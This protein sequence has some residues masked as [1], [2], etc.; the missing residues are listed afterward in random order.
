MAGSYAPITSLYHNPLL[1]FILIFCNIYANLMNNL[2]IDQYC[3]GQ[4]DSR[5]FFWEK[6]KTH[7][8]LKKLEEFF[9]QLVPKTKTK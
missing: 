4:P 8:T 9:L 3:T 5:K 2:N 6:I 7:A 1:L